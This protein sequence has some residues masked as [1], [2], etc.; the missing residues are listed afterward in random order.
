[1]TEEKAIQL[2]TE[3]PHLFAGKDLSP[4]ENLMCFGFDCGD[5]WFTLIRE[6]CQKIVALDPESNCIAVQVKEKF[7]G[8]RFYVHGATDKIYDLIEE[9]EEKSFFVCEDCGTTEGVK[10]KDWRGWIL[11]LCPV[12]AEKVKKGNQ[13]NLSALD[14]M[15]GNKTKEKK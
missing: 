13:G 12:C 10:T 11:S 14:L 9:A 8:L 6:L 3:F 1:M 2:F 15:M 4:R 7:G 5:G